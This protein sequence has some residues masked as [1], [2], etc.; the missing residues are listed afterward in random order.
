MIEVWKDIPGHVNYQASNLGRIK[1]LRSGRTLKPFIKKN[2]YV[3][4]SLGASV[5][6]ELHYFIAVTFLGPRIN[7]AE[8]NHKDFNRSNN[9]LE[10][11]EWVSRN[12][13]RQHSL[14]HARGNTV[15]LTVKQVLEIRELMK[16]KE[17][18]RVDLCKKYKVDRHTLANIAARRTWKWL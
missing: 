1:S 10:N 13:N 7:K 2:G 17:N 8:V 5:R 18:K 14:N 3:Y 15:K 11:L 6:K 16:S 9:K 12:Q 4:I